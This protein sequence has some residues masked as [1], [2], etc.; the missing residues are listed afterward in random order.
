MCIRLYISNSGQPRLLKPP[1]HNVLGR[2]LQFNR[3]NRVSYISDDV[4]TG[5]EL[6]LSGSVDPG[7]DVM[8]IYCL[9]RYDF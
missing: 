7:Q 4:I 1:K 6:T 3:Q 5:R 9:C 8:S 2:N